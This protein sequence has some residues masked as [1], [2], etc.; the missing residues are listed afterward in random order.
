[1]SNYP[2]GLTGRDID[3]MEGFCYQCGEDGGCC[4]EEDCC[5][6]EDEG[7]DPDMLYERQREGYL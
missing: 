2:D 7:P 4:G 3:E 6:H 5:C 1:M